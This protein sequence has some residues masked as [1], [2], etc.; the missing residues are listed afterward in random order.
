MGRIVHC[1]LLVGGGRGKKP[2][3]R[4]VMRELKGFQMN[5]SDIPIHKLKKSKDLFNRN[6]ISRFQSGE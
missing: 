5:M 2:A 1:S 4:K 3:Q 6:G